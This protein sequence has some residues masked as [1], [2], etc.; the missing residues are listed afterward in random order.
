MKKD[1]IKSF[2]KATKKIKEKEDQP[3]LKV[4]SYCGKA[5]EDWIATLRYE[6]GKLLL[7]KVICGKCQEKRNKK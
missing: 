1:L 7:N 2:K 3:V 5:S 6:S 4:C